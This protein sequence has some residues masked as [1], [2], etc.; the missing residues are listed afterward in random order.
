MPVFETP[1][2]ISVEFELGVGDVEITAEDRTDTVVEVRPTDEKDA[3]DVKAA[4]QIRVEY[5]NG[6]LLIKGPKHGVPV[7]VDFSRKSRSVDVSIVLPTGSRVRGEAAMADL[8]GSGRL[9][10][11]TYKTSTA[12]IRLEHVGRL[13]L[14]T[15]G[16][17]GV[18]RVDGDAEVATAT[19][20]I[21]LTEVDGAID[22]KNS[23]GDIEIGRVTGDVRARTSNGDITV[24]HASGDTT[25][26]KTANGN[27]RVAEVTRGSLVLKTGSGDLEIGIG[28]DSPAKLDLN[29]GYG[30]VNNTLEEVAK[31]L[32]EA[33]EVR[34]HTSYGDI[35]IQ[36]A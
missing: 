28:G 25:E 32:G 6:V 20:R 18:G 34:A 36:R 24:G 15:A 8:R 30:R 11:C 19:G 22:A 10:E 4:D 1:K 9:G 35:T 17:I 13:N 16:H 5:N 29:T 12:N 3:S 27:I 23:N 31:S 33:I 21:R 14:R 26:A 2:P 7:V